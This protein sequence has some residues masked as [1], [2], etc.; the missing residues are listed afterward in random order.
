MR[1]ATDLNRA[2]TNPVVD[3]VSYGGGIAH[4]PL[5]TSASRSAPDELTHVPFVGFPTRA[6]KR[7]PRPS[8]SSFGRRLEDSTWETHGRGQRF[9]M[10][11]PARSAHR[12]YAPGSAGSPLLR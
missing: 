8:P 7:E 11:H 5:P 10:E 3:L 4:G 1:S 2:P 9:L 6:P 12:A